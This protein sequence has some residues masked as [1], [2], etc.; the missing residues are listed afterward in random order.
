MTERWQQQYHISALKWNTNYV[1]VAFVN[2]NWKKKKNPIGIL[3]EDMTEFCGENY[4][5]FVLKHCKSV[6]NASWSI[7]IKVICKLT[8]DVTQF[9]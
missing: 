5:R 3:I 9:Q 6:T 1:F 7:K 2:G 4:Q 8:H